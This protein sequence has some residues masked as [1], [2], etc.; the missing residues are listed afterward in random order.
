MSVTK[1]LTSKSALGEDNCQEVVYNVTSD[2][3]EGDCPQEYTLVRT[4]T[5]TDE[6]NEP[7][8][9]TQTIT[10]VDSVAPVFTFVPADVTYECDVD[11]ELEDAT[12]EDNCQVVVSDVTSETIAGDCPQEYMIVRTFTISDECNEPVVATQ[13][14][15]VVDTTA[16]SVSDYDV[17]TS[18][19]CEDLESVPGPEFEDNCGEVTVTLETQNQ[20]GGCMGVLVRFYTAVDECGNTATATQYITILDNTPPVIITPAD[21]TVECDNLP[22]APGAEGADSF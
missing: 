15:I 4:F 10:V 6:C 13:T 7:V 20:S 18:A 17:E 22:A 8:S 1:K 16:P 14:I 12:S 21:E 11:F 3:T 9:A 2:T 19:N 5:L